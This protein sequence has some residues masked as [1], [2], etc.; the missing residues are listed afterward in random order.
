MICRI[1]GQCCDK[2]QGDMNKL[3]QESVKKFIQRVLRQIPRGMRGIHARGNFQL[4]QVMNQ[5]Q[6]RIET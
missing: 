2:S 3:S 4:G 5:L 1:Y 6:G